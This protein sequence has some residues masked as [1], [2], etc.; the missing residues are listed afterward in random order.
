MG[1]QNGAAAVESGTASPQNHHATQHVQFQVYTQ[2]NWKPGLEEMFAHRCSQ[3]LKCGNNS[4]FRWQVNALP[5]CGL[6]AQRNTLQSQQGKNSWHTR[7]HRWTPS[8][9]HWVKKASCKSTN[10]GWVHSHQESRAVRFRDREQSWG[11]HGESGGQMGQPCLTKTELP[12]GAMTK[13]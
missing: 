10:P 3:K 5:T 4:S 6:A 12:S 7:R 11:Y 1:M 8:I 9:W 13:F 2:K